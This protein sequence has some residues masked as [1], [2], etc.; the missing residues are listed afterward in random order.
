LHYYNALVPKAL[1]GSS[2]KTVLQP[3]PSGLSY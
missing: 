3:R 2:N 1:G